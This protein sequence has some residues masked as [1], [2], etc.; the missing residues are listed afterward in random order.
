MVSEQDIQEDETGADDEIQ[1]SDEV[2]A[3]ED[4]AQDDSIE[5]QLADANAKIDEHWDRIVRMQAEQDN[6]RKRHSRDLE[7]AHKY[8]ADSLLKA[9][10][11]VK[12]SLEMGIDAA[13]DAADA[14]AVIEGMQLTAKMFADALEKV[15]VTIVDPIGEKLDPEMHQAMSIIETD[16]HEPDTVVTVM[17]KGYLLNERLMRPAMV[18]VAKAAS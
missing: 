5:T 12:D 2:T 15:G 3:S 10:L 16:E 9:L 1:S 7:N 14:S 18:V 4:A 6:L 17:Q 11:P 13:T 8:G